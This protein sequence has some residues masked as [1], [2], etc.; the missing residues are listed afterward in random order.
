MVDL[1]VDS[2]K[3]KP[4]RSPPQAWEEPR[5]SPK[6]SGDSVG[7][8]AIH[9]GEDVNNPARSSHRASLRG[10]QNHLYFSTKTV[11]WTI[12][13]H[14]TCPRYPLCREHKCYRVSR[15]DLRPAV[16]FAGVKPMPGS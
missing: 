6:T 13:P 11:L 5:D 15:Q 10:T 16:Q 9:G 12:D 4:L 1:R 2:P 8:P 7:I 3:V 14:S